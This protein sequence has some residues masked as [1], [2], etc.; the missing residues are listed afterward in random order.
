MPVTWQRQT[1]VSARIPDPPLFSSTILNEPASLA[2]GRG[3]RVGGGALYYCCAGLLF[4]EDCLLRGRSNP[5]KPFLCGG[6][7]QLAHASRITWAAFLVG[8]ARTRTYSLVHIPL[9]PVAVWK[10]DHVSRKAGGRHFCHGVAIPRFDTPP[11]SRLLVEK[12]LTHP[13]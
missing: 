9:A 3:Q 6:L 8:P 5:T 10:M 2:D 13:T 1:T 11:F 7:S 4:I 12:H